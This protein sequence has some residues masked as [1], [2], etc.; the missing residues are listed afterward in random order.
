MI[1]ASKLECRLLK[2]LEKPP[3]YRPVLM[4]AAAQTYESLKASPSPFY[5]RLLCGLMVS[6]RAAA[7]LHP[8][9]GANL[10]AYQLPWCESSAKLGCPALNLPSK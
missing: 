2:G 4:L 6:T 1:C 5:S 9:E 3:F 7:A 8:G 10:P